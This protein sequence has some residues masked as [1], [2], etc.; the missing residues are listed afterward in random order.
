M[1]A[2]VK[3]AVVK[4]KTE[5]DTERMPADLAKRLR[6][7]LDDDPTLSWDQALARIAGRRR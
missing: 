7:L 2:K 4:I 6:K 5:P 1:L 3:A